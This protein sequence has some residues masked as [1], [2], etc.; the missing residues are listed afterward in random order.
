MNTVDSSQLETDIVKIVSCVR[1]REEINLNREIDFVSS[2]QTLQ[3]IKV[4]MTRAKESLIVCGH[5]QTLQ[6]NETMRHLINNAKNRGVD[7]I[8]T[9]DYTCDNLRPLLMRP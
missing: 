3:R 1:A 2:V 6:L 4:A 5:F 8:V 7:H 9:S